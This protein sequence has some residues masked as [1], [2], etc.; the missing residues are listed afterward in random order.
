MLIGFMC[1]FIYLFFCFLIMELAI[2]G[3]S[4]QL[5]ADRSEQ[6]RKRIFGNRLKEMEY[7]Q[8]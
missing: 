1:D 5:Y 4:F 3:I 6:L 2:C 7:F 8:K